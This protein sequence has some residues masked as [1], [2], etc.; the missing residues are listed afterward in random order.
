MKRTIF[1]IIFILSTIASSWAHDFSA[2]A[3]TGQTLYYTISG[4]EVTVSPESTNYPYWSSSPTGNLDIPSS[5]IHNNQTYSVTSIDNYAFCGCSGLTSITIPNSVTSI[6]NYAFR[7]CSGITNVIFN[8]TNCNSMGSVEFPVFYNCTNVTSLTIGNSVQ[9]IPNFAFMGCTG[10]TNTIIPKSVTSIG[11]YAFDWTGLT[12]ITIPDSVTFIGSYAFRGCDSVIFN[13]I[14]CNSIG[15]VNAPVF[16]LIFLTIGDSVQKI[17]N[18]AFYGCSGLTSVTIPNSVTSIGSNA[19]TGCKGL[20]SVTIPN[21]VTS[22]G[23]YAFRSCDSLSNVIYNAINSRMGDA[24]HPVFYN[25]NHLKSITIGDSVQEIPYYAFNDCGHISS[26]YF[27]AIN[28]TVITRLEQQ[29]LFSVSSHLTSITIGNNVQ[30]I[31]NAV[32]SWC[33]HLT[34]ITIPNS[35]TT[36]ASGAFFQCTGLTNITIPN[37][38][39]SIGTYAFSNCTNI[40]SITLGSGLRF[41][42][43]YAFYE[44]DS[45]ALITCKAENPPY[46]DISSYRSRYLS[47]LVLVLVPCDALERYQSDTAWN[48]FY[49]IESTLTST[50]DITSADPARGGVSII[51]QPTCDN[52][53][54]QFRANAYNGFH[55]DH[56][57]DGNTDNPRYLVLTGDTTIFAHFLSDQGFTITV[58]SADPSMGS[59]TGSGTF[60]D[61]TTTTITATA[62][63]GY[64]FV[65]WQDGNNEHIRT[66]TVTADAT[67]TAYFESTQGIENT[68][69]MTDIVIRTIGSS[70]VVEGIANETIRLFDCMGRCLQTIRATEGCTFQVPVPGVY[71]LQAGH[72]PAQRVVVLR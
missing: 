41:I 15:R 44:I 40:K 49:N 61:G 29:S 5:V 66:I 72:Y 13:A 47:P 58:E 48:Y 19:F 60:A 69:D 24:D 23:D 31:P 67:Y 8:A 62:N 36:I 46:F 4:T 34:D 68:T 21:S 50:L 33:S 57:S 45:L 71:M 17:P 28:C 12:S 7:D 70:I 11:S 63:T 2:V 6:G 30:K 27:N 51:T 32:F 1:F 54:A 53:Q 52:R 16:N 56:W 22:I 38:V 35:V 25:C 26:V 10:L 59:V 39:Y 18:N 42:G 43:G 20:T 65:Q 64:R 9:S 14:N 37:S 55:F 3:P